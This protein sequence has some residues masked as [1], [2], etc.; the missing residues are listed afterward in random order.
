MSDDDRFGNLF[1]KDPGKLDD[2][3]NA[4]TFDMESSPAADSNEDPDFGPDPFANHAL[5]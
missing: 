4:S 3:K 1:A 5:D 2:S